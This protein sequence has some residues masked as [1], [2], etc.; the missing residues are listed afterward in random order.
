LSIYSVVN[1][2]AVD[3]SSGK[4][5]IGVLAENGG[6]YSDRWDGAGHS[7]PL[8]G[9]ID[10][11]LTEVGAGAGELDLLAIISGP[12]SFTGLRI[13]LSGIFGIAAASGTPVIAIDTFSSMEASVPVELYPLL[14]SIHSRRDE[15]Y[16]K[17]CEG[18]GSGDEPFIE[19]VRGLK[20]RSLPASR[21]CGPG[22]P[23]LT[24]NLRSMMI[25]DY[26]YAGPEYEFPDMISVCKEAV[27]RFKSG[28]AK[29]VD[30][31]VEL[32]YMTLSQAELK[33]DARSGQTDDV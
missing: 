10:S 30:S 24:E 12:G 5:G 25:N 7:E 11:A 26:K 9:R 3:T 8:F 14:I 27:S 6:E 4:L 22:S 20:S 13:G 33:F 16:L 19:N 21:V 17:F 23:G 28:Y 29:T 1:V 15:Y 31:G 32:Y 18:P 2:L